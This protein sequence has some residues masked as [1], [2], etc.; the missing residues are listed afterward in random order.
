MEKNLFNRT[1]SFYK[2][3]NFYFQILCLHPSV[4]LSIH[5]FVYLFYVRVFICNNICMCVS[6][7]VYVILA[8]PLFFHFFLYIHNF[9]VLFLFF[10]YFWLFC[11][12]FFLPRIRPCASLGHLW[13]ITVA[14]TVVA[15]TIAA[16]TTIVAADSKILT[17]S[18]Y[19]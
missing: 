7:R 16:A 11:P 8:N 18:C 1:F 10:E 14:A 2:T 13:S 3:F 9:N 6:M 17:Y 4:R 19:I 12:Y 5:P 15:A